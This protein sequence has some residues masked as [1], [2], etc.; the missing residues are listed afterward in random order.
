LLVGLEVLGKKAKTR[1]LRKKSP[2]A[3]GTR[4][5]SASNGW[6]EKDQQ[7][8][9]GKHESRRWKRARGLKEERTI[10]QGEGNKKLPTSQVEYG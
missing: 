4:D 3:P 5:R 7:L 2:G 8:K 1:V 10:K 6:N 9:K